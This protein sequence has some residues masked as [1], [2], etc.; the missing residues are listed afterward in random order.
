[1]IIF[2]SHQ[3]RCFRQSPTQVRGI[4][5]FKTDFSSWRLTV[6]IDTGPIYRFQSKYSSKNDHNVTFGE[7]SEKSI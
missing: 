6:F 4:Y 5:P 2:H 1:M 7:F 3:S